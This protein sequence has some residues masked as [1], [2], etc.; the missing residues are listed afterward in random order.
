[1][2]SESSPGH[3]VPVD[4]T[5]P[6][7]SDAER[8]D[9]MAEEHA[10]QNSPSNVS[11]RITRR[12]YISHFLST[13]NSRV[14]EFG[15]VLYLATIFP[16]TL[17]PMSVYALVRGISAIVFAPAVGQYIDSQNRL[18]VVRASIVYQRVAVAI[19]CSAFVSFML[20]EKLGEKWKPGMLAMVSLL[21]CVEKLCSIMNLVSVEKDWVVVVAGD[22]QEALKTLN[23]QM[24][25]IDL[26]CKLFGPLFIALIDG[27]S[28]KIAILVNLGMNLASVVIEYFAIAQVYHDVPGLQST[29]RNAGRRA[30]DSDGP[31][32]RNIPTRARELART[33]IADHGFF[34]H[35]TAFQA[36]MAGALLYLTVLSFNGQMVTYLLT[37]GYTST[38]VGIARTVSVGFEVLATWAAPWLMGRIGPVRSG[39]WMSCWQVTALGL[40]VTVFWKF[41]DS[42]A[43]V[44]A[45]G[46]VIGTILSRLGLFGFD[47]CAQVIVQEEVEPE[48]RG[49]FSSIEAAWQNAFELLSFAS[50]II[51]YDPS[52]F[53]WP[54]LISLIAVACAGVLYSSFVRSRRGHLLH[55]EVLSK[56]CDS[57]SWKQRGR[58]RAMERLLNRSDS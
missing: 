28:T 46:L 22:D 3:V 41:A 33:T 45:T 37:A 55:L 47:L 39:L 54:S 16:G 30:V 10:S 31:W 21:A 18:K 13:W 44:G 19:S 24:R 53:K 27:F 17:L 11:P 58:D 38:Q 1:M 42:W 23:A 8:R 43:V 51:F 14:F 25:R 52:D 32:Y 36:S 35:H 12:L 48:N 50:T 15:A 4:A 57:G 34:F 20:D 49:A 6:L 7:L 5:T 29:K 26:M 56:L 2:A 40:G 9:S